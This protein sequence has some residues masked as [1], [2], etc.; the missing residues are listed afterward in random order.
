MRILRWIGVIQVAI[1]MIG[2]PAPARAAAGNVLLILGDDMGV[3]VSTFYPTWIRRPT[4]PPPPALPNLAELAHSGVLFRNAWANAECSPTRATLFTGR[5]GFRTG[6]GAYVKVGRPELSKDEIGM[7]EVMRAAHGD[8]YLLAHIGKWH[9]SLLGPQEPLLH[10][11]PYYAGPAAPLTNMLDYFNWEKNINGVVSQSTTYATTD[12]VNETLSAIGSA[13]RQDRPFLIWLA[14]NSVHEPYHQ[15]PVGLGGA[16]DPAAGDE[17]RARYAAMLRAMDSEIGRLMEGVDLATT[18]VIFMGDNGTP[19]AVVAAPYDSR[20]KS[21]IYEGGVHV[22]LLIAGAGVSNP[23]RISSALANSVDI[24]PTMLE[25]AG[26]DWRQHVGAE[27]DGVSLM[28]VLRGEAGSR[29]WAYAERFI[30]AYDER[31]Q[32]TVRTN[33]YKLIVQHGTRELYDLTADP[34]ESRNLLAGQLDA[35]QQRALD[36]L[37]RR[38]DMLIASR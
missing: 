36:L 7:P 20:A 18:T 28:P 33:R 17:P 6:I 30:T 9:L 34:L 29:S 27:I 10:G 25:L 15:P 38:M 22:P 13:E 3:D 23:G 19:A 14:F 37:Q 1:T 35:P 24:F 26:V 2:S 4:V 11:W 5:Y 12:Q 8:R 21:T 32:R 16:A 31:P